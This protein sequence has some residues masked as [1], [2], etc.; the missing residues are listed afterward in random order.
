M[1]EKIK[2][3]VKALLIYG[4][5]FLIILIP[6]LFMKYHMDDIAYSHFLDRFNY[7]EFLKYRYFNRSSRLIIET[8]AIFL[9]RLD[10]K[11]WG[12]L[13]SLIYTFLI[14]L[15]NKLVNK[16]NDLFIKIK[17]LKSGITYYLFHLLCTLLIRNKC[18]H[19]F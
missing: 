8:V 13:N 14:Y 9:L 16:E 1:K 10:I 2:K 19:L 5:I 18:V 17:R 15:I 7:I 4:I 3:S 11:V 12:V 6:H